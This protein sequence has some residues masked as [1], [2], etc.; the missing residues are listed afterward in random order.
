MAATGPRI[1]LPDTI[2]A[3]DV[4]EVKTLIRHI[5]ETG[6]RHD[7]N[8]KPIPRDIINTFI[9]KF[10][11]QQVFRAEF[12]P[13]ISA[14]PYLAFQLRVPGPGTIEITWIDDEGVAV[15]ATAPVT[16]S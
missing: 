1:K 5:M 13:G 15:S 11:G 12:G 8:G 14:N 7:K 3:G 16:L 6:N 10:D 2:K 9:A 4:I